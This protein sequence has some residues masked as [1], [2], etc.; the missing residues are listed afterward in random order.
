M[1]VA[2]VEV[3]VVRVP[4]PARV[5]VVPVPARVEDVNGVQRLPTLELRKLATFESDKANGATS[6]DVGI[7]IVRDF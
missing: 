5:P 1:A 3:V 6:P 2:V 7:M 4:V